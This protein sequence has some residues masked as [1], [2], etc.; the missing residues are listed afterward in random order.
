MGG[1]AHKGGTCL[2]IPALCGRQRQA[3]LESEVSLFCISSSQTAKLHKYHLKT[4]EV[5]NGRPT[6]RTPP[7]WTTPII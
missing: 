3:E 5:P 1:Y 4:K 2:L 7:K 6:K